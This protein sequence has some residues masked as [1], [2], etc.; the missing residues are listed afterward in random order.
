MDEFSKYTGD[1]KKKKKKNG[2][3]YMLNKKQI[4][5]YRGKSP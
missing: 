5:E 4:V 2:E 3:T 1:K